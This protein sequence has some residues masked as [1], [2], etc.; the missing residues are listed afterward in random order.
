ML[1]GALHDLA[2][3]SI[4]DPRSSSHLRYSR[5]TWEEDLNLLHLSTGYLER[6]WRSTRLKIPFNTNPNQKLRFSRRNSCPIVHST[7]GLFLTQLTFFQQ[8]WRLA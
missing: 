7:V 3:Q 2:D 8:K 6:P 4:L 1:Y 5:R